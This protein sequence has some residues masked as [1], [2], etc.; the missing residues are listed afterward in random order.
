[1][2]Y[3]YI[4]LVEFVA[5]DKTENFLLLQIGIFCMPPSSIIPLHNHPGMTVL[6]KLLYGTMHVKSYDWVDLPELP[7]SSQGS[8]NLPLF[9]WRFKYLS[10]GLEYEHKH[11]YCFCEGSLHDCLLGDDMLSSLLKLHHLLLL[12]R[13]FWLALSWTS[14]LR[15]QVFH[16]DFCGPLECHYEYHTVV[17]S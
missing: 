15:K 5:T 16:H 12:D 10:S 14:E 2:K 9:T 3:E 1:M 17:L 13:L 11:R 7:E 6:S 8:L 4:A